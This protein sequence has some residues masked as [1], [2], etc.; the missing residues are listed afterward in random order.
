[1]GKNDVIG[2]RA[3]EI[4]KDWGVGECFGKKIGESDKRWHSALL[5]H[6]GE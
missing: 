3:F 2:N 5:K 4:V 1:M 6:Y